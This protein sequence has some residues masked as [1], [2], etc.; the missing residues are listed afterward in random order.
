V[1][2]PLP[3]S[4]DFTSVKPGSVP[5]WW[6]NA[7][8]KSSVREVEGNQVL[9]KHADNPFTKRARAYIGPTNLHDYTVQVDFNGV[10]KRRQLGDAGVVAQRYNLILF[11]NHQ[12]LELQSWQPETQRTVAVP[13]SWKGNT[14]YRMKLRVENK[15]DGS[16]HAQGKVWPAS[17]PEPDKWL[18]EKIEKGG[19]KHG[20]P[21]LY[22]DAPFEVYFDNLKVAAN[23]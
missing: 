16:V 2:P 14:W 13:Y 19:H 10:E 7:T 1:I 18:I 15:P 8:G 6:I 23:K 21:G 22:A 12:R 20:S 9:V 11:G 4:Q 17:E 3:W 5:P